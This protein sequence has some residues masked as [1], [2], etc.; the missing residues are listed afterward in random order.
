[1][2][3]TVE[4]LGVAATTPLGLRSRPQA[5]GVAVR[6]LPSGQGWL[7]GHL[8]DLRVVFEPPLNGSKIYYVLWM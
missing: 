3:K 5:L 7:H 2:K 4:D 8:Q 6:P 1:M